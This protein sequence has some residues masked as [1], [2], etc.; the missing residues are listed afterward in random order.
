MTNMPLYFN[1][2]KKSYLWH[3]IGASDSVSEIISPADLNG[4]LDIL[5]SKGAERLENKLR[6]TMRVNMGKISEG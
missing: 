2:L 6:L 1:F 5:R 3:R 4:I